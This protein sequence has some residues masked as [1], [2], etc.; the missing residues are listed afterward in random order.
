MADLASLSDALLFSSDIASVQALDISAAQI[1]ELLDGFFEVSNT[2]ES[3]GLL[4]TL[5]P[6]DKDQM[7]FGIAYSLVE[8]LFD[9]ENLKYCEI[10]E[11]RSSR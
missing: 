6:F 8:D 5:Q 11:L 10:C 3:I 9:H 2:E 7:R 4:N 1:T